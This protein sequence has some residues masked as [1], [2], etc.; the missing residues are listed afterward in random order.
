MHGSLHDQ[1]P[2]WYVWSW[3]K[4]EIGYFDEWEDEKVN[5]AALLLFTQVRPTPSGTMLE[6]RGTQSGLKALKDAGRISRRHLSFFLSD[7]ER[8][9]SLSFQNL[10]HSANVF[11]R[12]INS[13]DQSPS[14]PSAMNQTSRNE[15]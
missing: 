9:E 6:L 8:I 10:N 15:R 5:A 4:D 3:C 13:N 14:L 1:G 12:Y 2:A 11:L 7:G